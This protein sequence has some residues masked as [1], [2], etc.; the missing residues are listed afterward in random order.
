MTLDY[1]EKN[2]RLIAFVVDD[3]RAAANALADDLQKFKDV[4]EVYIFQSYND[5]T[6]PLLE[7]QPDV[8]FLDVE[9]PGKTGIEFLE[10]IRHRINFSFH[11]VFYT[12]FSDYMIDAIRQSA[13]DFL[14]KPY[15]K[16]EL[17]QVVRRLTNEPPH[18]TLSNQP[19]CNLGTRKIAL[20]TICELLLLNM[21]EILML[22]YTSSSRSWQLILTDGSMHQLRKGMSAED[23]L[24]LHPALGRISSNCILNLTYLA[25]IENSS[26]RCRLS[27]PFDNMELNASRRYFSKLKERFEL[28]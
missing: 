26:Q 27:P 15:K 14:L 5:A 16:E 22:Q 25:A 12:A 20:Q 19:P 1:K 7:L 11:V 28:L 21:E 23:L 17:Q 18:H 10:S 9:M 13:F 2:R 3:D 24:K 8:L 4:G 6:L